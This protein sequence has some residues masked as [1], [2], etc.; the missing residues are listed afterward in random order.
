M[1]YV[2]IFISFLWSSVFSNEIQAQNKYAVMGTVIDSMQNK[3]LAGATIIMYYI[4]Q[5]NTIAGTSTS[6]GRGEFKIEL[7]DTGTYLLECSFTGFSKKSRTIN[8]NG[9]EVNAGVIA[10]L[11]QS[12]TL[13]GIT[14]NAQRKLIEQTDDKIIYNVENDPSAR[15]Q[16][17]CECRR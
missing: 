12:A 5:P 4:G 7:K 6:D 17:L 14:V 15:M 8:I 9:T 10:L 13:S 2:L 16:T 1:K 11:S 3:S